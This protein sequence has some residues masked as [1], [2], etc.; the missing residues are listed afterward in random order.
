MKLRQC[1]LLKS[2]VFTFIGIMLFIYLQETFR[3]KLFYPNFL[4]NGEKTVRAI[5]KERKESIDVITFGTSHMEYGFVPMELYEQYHVKAYNLATSGQPVEMSYYLMQYAMQSQSPVVCILDA[6]CLFGVNRQEYTWRYLLDAMPLGR[7]KVEYAQIMSRETG[8]Q[9]RYALFPFF[10][11]HSRWK[12]LN[13]TDFESE[14]ASKRLY[15]KGGDILSYRFSAWVTVDEMNQWAEINKDCIGYTIEFFNGEQENM[16]YSSEAQYTA[17]IAE[18]N[19]AYLKKM[20]A[21]C[22]KEG[23]D[24]FVLKIPAIGYPQQYLGAWTKER[25]DK[26]KNICDALAITYMDLSYGC[27]IGIDWSNDTADGG[28]HLNLNGAEK[29]TDYLGNY[30]VNHYDVNTMVDADWNSDLETYHRISD[31][32]H[33]QLE[34]N[35]ISYLNLLKEKY[36]DKLILLA[37]SEDIVGGLS[38][39]DIDSMRAIGLKSDFSENGY[40]C[41]FVAVLDHGMT[42]YEAM[43]NMVIEYVHS[44]NGHNIRLA[45]KGWNAGK[46]ENNTG[47]M[48]S[49]M[50]DNTQ[51]AVNSAGMNIVVYDSEKDLVIDSV[52]FDT[53]NE[54]HYCTRNASNI[55]DYMCAIEAYYWQCEKMH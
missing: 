18:E 8:I 19:I 9:M 21:L 4:H 29:V 43:S 38:I 31:I 37:G 10:R 15:S 7:D 25:S 39:E 11:Y 46:S 20:K 44:A 14:I 53:R 35:Y 3:A 12:E 48:A 24:L 45:S 47:S 26:T 49:I 1:N 54:N 40:Q 6:S 23:V 33:L 42:V 52:C 30:I 55:W 13:I 50:I 27:D 51:I 28:M 22:K 5:K 17:E 16:R 36:P 41:S 2:I 32:A 34:Q